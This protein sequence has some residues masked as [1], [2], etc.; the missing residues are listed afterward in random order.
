MIMVTWSYGEFIEG[1]Y[2]GFIKEYYDIIMNIGYY[3]YR[4]ESNYG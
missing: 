4:I 1:H 2:G 3:K